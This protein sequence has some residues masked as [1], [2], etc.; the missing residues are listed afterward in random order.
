MKTRLPHR[1]AA[2]SRLD[3]QQMNRELSKAVALK[4]VHQD[5]RAVQHGSKLVR[6]LLALRL[7]KAE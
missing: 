7:V 2:I 4:N 5:A 1:L 3:R 6:L